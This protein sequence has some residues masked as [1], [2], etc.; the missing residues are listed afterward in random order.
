MEGAVSIRTSKE[1][2]D[3][4]FVI[5]P[6]PAELGTAMRAH[7]SRYMG[8][9]SPA[10]GNDLIKRLTEK[11]LGFQD[12]EFT[13]IFSK[14]FRMF[15]DPV[16]N[17]AVEWVES[18]VN[19]FGGKRTGVNYVS[20]DEREK[21]SALRKDSYDVFWRCVR[22][23]KPDVGA[24]HCDYQFWEIVRGTKD[25]VE[26]PFDYDE[27][28]KIWVPLMGCDPTNSLQVVPGS[29]AQEV[30]TD[31]VMTKNGYKPVIQPQWL[32]QY[33]KSF[34]CPLT[35]FNNQCVLFHDKL[36]HRGPANNTQNL[37]LSG[38]LTILLKL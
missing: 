26:C 7:I 30:P 36:V 17:L 11:S 1:M 10:T 21:N 14:P 12:E 6:F 32:N 2:Q 31:R 18:L 19:Q 8:V 13:R 23:G 9:S 28:W 33:E 38:E 37:R 5:F 4:G 22:P 29:H 25:D 20:T 3:N 15:P 27:R 16:A 35:T 34:V 24:A